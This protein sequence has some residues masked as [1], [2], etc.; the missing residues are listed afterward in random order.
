MYSSGSVQIQP[1]RPSAISATP[2][3]YAR[4]PTSPA[5]MGRLTVADPYRAPTWGARSSVPTGPPWIGRLLSEGA[6]NDRPLSVRRPRQYAKPGLA[7]RT[8][9]PKKLTSAH[10]E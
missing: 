4:T 6:A 3:S 5:P 2:G 9:H 10:S 1:N 7:P 8:T